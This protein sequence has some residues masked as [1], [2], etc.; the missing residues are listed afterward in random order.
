M[1]YPVR[2]IALSGKKG[3]GKSIASEHINKI[4]N[5]HKLSFATPLKNA[6]SEIFDFRNNECSD[7]NKKEVIDYRWGISPRELMQK[8]GTE[9]F[10]DKIK[11]ILPNLN[12]PYNNIWISNMYFRIKEI[13]EI[14]KYSIYKHN[15]YIIDDCRFEDE[16]N[17]IKN[18]GGY[19]IRINRKEV[20][21]KL[22][23]HESEKGCS[24]DFEVDNNTSIEDFKIRLDNLIRNS[25][26]W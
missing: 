9:V 25:I 4:Y 7:V 8:I 21:S 13:E 14:H 2:I 15:T 19:V 20:Y 17:F 16:Y 10:R 12:M 6:I 18:L 22:D 3:C 26:K 24:F 23:T 1:L 5:C 11:E